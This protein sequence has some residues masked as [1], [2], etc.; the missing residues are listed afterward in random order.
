MSKDEQRI[1][2]ELK[3]RM[4]EFKA[5]LKDENKKQDF[6][7]SIPGSQI[8]IR[9][10]IFLPSTNPEEYVDGLYLYMNDEG[11]ISHAEY[12]FQDMS[13][14]QVINIPKKTFQ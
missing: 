10:E 9:F 6:Q 3:S 4:K 13:D 5:A 1:L 7:D 14:V 8:L 12:Y 11:Q 2:K